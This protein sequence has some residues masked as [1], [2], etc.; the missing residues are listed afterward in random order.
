MPIYCVDMCF[1]NNSATIYEF[2]T[3]KTV[4]IKQ[5]SNK[6]L[7]ITFDYFLP[8]DPR[9]WQHPYHGSI[10]VLE[11]IDIQRLKEIIIEMLPIE[12]QI[13]IRHHCWEF[14]ELQNLFLIKNIIPLSSHPIISLP[15]S[16]LKQSAK[17]IPFKTPHTGIY[18]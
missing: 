14:I 1:T 16:K 12:E 18:E 3:N 9:N 10:K 17:I 15:G 5:T 13:N 2:N 6:L 7:K 4:G 8:D 11:V